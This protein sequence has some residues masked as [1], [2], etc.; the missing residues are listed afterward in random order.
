MPQE[1]Q[2]NYYYQKSML[3][4][5]LVDKYVNPKIRKIIDFP[6]VKAKIGDAA[7]DDDALPLP[8]CDRTNC[9]LLQWQCSI[10]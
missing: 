5:P 4:S 7:N 10:I 6:E 1:P 3:P 2:M 9:V 8:G